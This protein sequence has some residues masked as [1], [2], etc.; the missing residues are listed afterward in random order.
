ML[1]CNVASD[2]A[3]SLP[4][5]WSA[6]QCYVLHQFPLLGRGP[7][8]AILLP[9]PNLQVLVFGS[10]IS[11]RSGVIVSSLPLSIM[12]DTTHQRPVM[13]GLPEFHGTFPT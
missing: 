11:R 9:G 13:L 6:Y 3:V 12:Q 5:F 1:E 2:S 10:H 4:T 7:Y 8:L